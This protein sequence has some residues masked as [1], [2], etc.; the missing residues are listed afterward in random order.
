M[1]I[2]LVYLLHGGDGK[3]NK[4]EHG[5]K[6]LLKE[7]DDYKKHEFMNFIKEALMWVI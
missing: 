2:S 5:F 1:I 3:P 4:I 6:N 7:D